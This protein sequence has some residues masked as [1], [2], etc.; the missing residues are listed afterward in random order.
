MTSIWIV[1]W[2]STHWYSQTPKQNCGVF[3]SQAAAQ[4]YL[5]NK[6]IVKFEVYELSAQEWKRALVKPTE[7]H[8]AVYNER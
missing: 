6:R 5:D 3:T 7:V 2:L 1:L 4:G 8:S